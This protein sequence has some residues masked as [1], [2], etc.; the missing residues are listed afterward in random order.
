[1]ANL[2]DVRRELAAASGNA[3]E[4]E[5][6]L[7]VQREHIKRL[8]RELGQLER[9]LDPRDQR[10]REQRDRLRAD[11]ERGRAH[12]ARLAAAKRAALDELKGAR[13]RFE[14]VLDPRRATG[15]LDSRFPILLFPVRLETRFVAAPGPPGPPAELL[16]RIYPDDC[17]VDSFEP[18]LSEA[19]VK[20][21]RRYWSAIFSSGGEETRERA[22]WRELCGAHGA[23][24]AVYLVGQYVPLAGSDPLPARTR[25]DDV[26]LV[27][28][29]DAAIASAAEKTAIV[30]Y[31]TATWRAG[32]DT[33]AFGDLRAAVGGARAE[34]IRQTLVPF[35]VKERPQP[36]A[37][38]ALVRVDVVFV[39]MTPVSAVAVKR[40]AWTRAPRAAILPDRFVLVAEGGGAHQ[41]LLGNPVTEPLAVGPDP[42]A[43]GAD[44]FSAAGADINVPDALKWMTD[45]DAAVAA[46][47]GFRVPLTPQQA[48]AGFERLYVIGLRLASDERTSQQE[49][50]SLIRDQFR[51]QAGFAILR[52][53]TPTNNTEESASGWSRVEEA[54]ALFVS[55][56]VAAE[57]IET[58]DAAATAPY[59]K[60]DGLALAEALGIGA[61][62]FQPIPGASGNDQADARAM[63]AALWPATLG[64]WMDTQMRPVFDAT[65]IE[66]TRRHFID[67]VSGRGAIPAVRVGRQPYGIVATTAF[68]RFAWLD[69]TERVPDGPAGAHF[70]FL[71]T[72]FALLRTL[73]E[74]YWRGFGENAPHVGQATS[75]PQKQLLDILGLHPASVDFHVHV[76]DSAD[77]LWNELKFRYRRRD[78]LESVMRREMQAGIGLLGTLGYSGTAPEI[79]EKFEAYV[80][81]PM[82]R[83][84]VD[85]APLSETEGLP[86]CTDTGQNYIEW[87]LDKAEHAFDDLRQQIGFS[88]G[89]LPNALLY[90]M[91]RHALQ[92]GYYGAAV[93]LHVANGLLPSEQVATTYREPAFIHVAVGTDAKWSESR[94][95]MLYDKPVVITGD[96]SRTVAE[97]IPGWLTIAGSGSVLADQIEALRILA[98]ASTAR[99][100]RAFA[101]HVDLCTYRWDAWMLSVVREQ[102][103]A[104]RRPQGAAEARR[105][106]IYLGA[107]GWLENVRPDRPGLSPATLNDELRLVF[108]TPGQPPLQRDA[109]SGGHVLAPSLNHA[110]TSAVLRSGYL[111]NASP[112][113]PDL[114]AVD[115]SSARVRVALQFVEGIR[116]G[117]PLGALLGYQFERRLHD[118]HAE[119]ETDAFIYQVRKAFPLAAKRIADSVEGEAD[120]T[121]IENVEARNVCDGLLLLEHVRTSPTKTYPWDKALERGTAA[122][123]AIINEEVTALFDIHDA[124]ADVAIA[125]SVHQLT[126]GNA[127][128]A[129]AAMDAYGKST[130]PPEPEVVRTPRSGV[131]LSHRVALHLPVDA[132]PPGGATPRAEAEPAIDRWLAGVLPAMN[133]LVVR[134]RYTDAVGGAGEQIDDVSMQAL[135]LRP[136]DL[137]YIAD[138]DSEAAMNDL[139]DRIARRV[140]ASNTLAPDAQLTIR[141]T[142][143]VPNRKTWFET[144][145]LIASLRSLIV[146]A[147]PLKPS[148]AALESEA[149][150]G[151]NAAVNVP[152]AR[153]TAARNQVDTLRQDAAALVTTLTPLVDPSAPFAG[154]VNAVDAALSD[155]HD[156]QRRAGLCGVA[157]AGS[158]EAMRAGRE[159]FALVRDKAHDVSVFWTAK[160]A[161]C[162]GGI[163]EATAP[164]TPE[165]LRVPALVR[166]EQA[167]STS[168]TVPP[169]DVA[170]FLPI[171]TARRAAFLGVKGQVEAVETSAATAIRPLWTAWSATF[172]PRRL[173]DITVIDTAK[174]ESQIRVLLADM[175]RQLT[176]LVRELEKRRKTADDAITAAGAAA[177]E[178]RAQ[179]LVDAASALFG[180]GFRILPR[181]TLSPSQADEWQN[182]Y[183]GRTS[184]LTHAGTLHDFPVDDW[185]YGIA[186]VRAR[187][188]DLEK[189]IQITGAFD[190][191]EPALD[192]IQLPF[193]GSEP[194][195][196]MDLPPAFDVTTAGEHLLYTAIY[197]AG[198]FDKTAD[199]H[200]GLMLDEWTEVIPGPAETAGLAFH[201]DRPSSEPPHAML[202]VTP[203]SVG[204]RWQWSDVERAVPE[205]FALAKTRAAEPSDV[206]ATPLARLLPAT[207]MAFTSGGISIASHL[208]AADV[209]I[210]SREV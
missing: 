84:A 198:G 91:L 81:G 171:V 119:A 158:G 11:I 120:D 181:F 77:R 164:G 83:P 128:R 157:L 204:E 21:L 3:R 51:S 53:G 155:F 97:F 49:L 113:N 161:E 189:V 13:D 37:D 20:N 43:E 206:S 5:R 60:K 72:L 92:L 67:R 148:D 207:L 68:S 7:S 209:M 47:M 40:Q 110:V 14:P 144:A 95:G 182:A 115:L 65:A 178:R 152:L 109:A 75:D 88:E 175:H 177:P 166:A 145:P 180:E 183:D 50:E 134:V 106:G 8:E 156:L 73:G 197:T 45:F 71:Q 160:L 188:H 29:V 76:F 23:G 90:H 210:A 96:P 146:N 15:E 124:I 80:E 167:V 168:Y 174:E 150:S 125:E 130:F 70:R 153:V 55:S 105:E 24:R 99:L 79:V 82:N 28:P 169:P 202:L 18:D 4:A 9:R 42:L 116:N 107:Y 131:S 201:Y 87:C 142:E 162:D 127:D 22:A 98:P 58:F 2:N 61:G 86:E 63:N 195:L 192:P 33:L 100:E 205:T 118:R 140:I 34:M 103:A 39:V 16:V 135:G 54:D 194:W 187:M 200:G 93:D 66:Q 199:A 69:R 136:I 94:Y 117:Q 159:W 208:H 173:H 64:Y 149:T 41:E 85:V 137:L 108:E 163:A 32:H 48:Q 26:I 27:I 122:Q 44:Q 38:R 25:S 193:V 59:E 17:L 104:M 121:A 185:L 132:A 101:E 172:A 6:A 179:L 111:N 133:E 36:G 10:H 112:A 143:P 114:F 190:L 30:T 46:G 186:R 129:A 203:A 12:T 141:Y 151:A 57:G 19:E 62:V 154:L 139:D 102:L 126:M 138:P 184:L 191:P 52:Q 35:N 176:G 31:W 89:K 196:A 123:E 165:S 1:M 74:A 147:R 78:A 170:T 56:R